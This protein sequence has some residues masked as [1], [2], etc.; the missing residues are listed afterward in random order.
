MPSSTT[1]ESAPA[2]TAPLK[3]QSRPKV[4]VDLIAWDPDSPEHVERMF[5]QRIACGWKSDYVEKWRGLQREGKM[6]IQWV[7]LSK[8][9]P[10]APTKLSQHLTKYPLEATPIHDTA[11]TLG[12]KPRQPSSE[13]FTPIGHIS[14]DSESP[15][16]DQADASK[17]MYCITTFY[18]SRAIQSGGLGS[19]AMDRVESE[20]VNEPL[21]ARVLSLDT[22][23]NSS[24]DRKEM[25]RD[26]GFEEPSVC[27]ISFG[28][29][30]EYL[31]LQFVGEE[32]W[33]GD[34]D[35]VND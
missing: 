28:Y 23:A 8:D 1:D 9:D 27:W 30:S 6:A 16:P 34:S 11:L 2:A 21:N 24:L 33:V 32:W 15:N 10:S 12:A 17:G 25:W 19:A 4:T 31:S 20:A 3:F 7:V 22:L 26:M 18:I 5:Q 35:E 29:F 13:P 14:L